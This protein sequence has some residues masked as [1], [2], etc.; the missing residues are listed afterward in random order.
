MTAI[1][2][3]IN[4]GLQYFQGFSIADLLDIM[5]VAFAVYKVIGFIHRTKT[6]RIAR[7]LV[8][9]FIVVWVSAKLQLNVLNFVLTKAIDVGVLALVVLFQPEIRRVLERFGKNKLTSVLFSREDNS[10]EMESVIV[11]TVLACIQ[12]SKEKTGALIVFERD[13]SLDDM[14]KTGTI[15]NA[16]VNAELLRNIFFN[17]SPLHDGAVIIEDGR[18]K[19]AGCMVPLSNNNNLS[20]DLGM[21]HRAG[22]GVSEQSDA[23]SVIVSEET[24]SI[25]FAVDGMLK[26]HLTPET[27]E[28]LL[29]NELIVDTGQDG[30]NKFRDRF[31]GKH[32]D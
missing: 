20:R 16:D 23:V 12:L 27:F 8:F 5:I 28:K 29:R 24:G 9:F 30:G 1:N 3:I 18:I 11:Q 2:G 13:I 6:A 25:A 22:I 19:A 31:K 4:Q 17:K 15:I 14:M 26:R 32:N 7:T 10:Q 21:R